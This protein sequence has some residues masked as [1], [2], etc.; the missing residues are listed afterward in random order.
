M[1]IIGIVLIILT[2][3][4][5]VSFRE[6]VFLN[7]VCALF[8][9]INLLFWH[10]RYSLALVIGLASSILV[11]LARQNHFGE[12]LVSLFIPILLMSL[13]DGFLKIEGRLSRMLH[14]ITG[15]ILS[16]LLSEVILKLLFLDSVFEFDVLLKQILVSGIIL[17]ILNL[18]SG[19]LLPKDNRGTRFL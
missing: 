12:T 13:V 3:I 9:L 18:I 19:S 4:F 2:T 15:L 7:G 1:I 6:I 5:E 8:I 16:I 10:K 14:S 11:D 17:T